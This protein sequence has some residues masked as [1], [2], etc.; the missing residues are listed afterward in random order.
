MI[1]HIESFPPKL[2]PLTDPLASRADPDTCPVSNAWLYAQAAH[3]SDASKIP[4]RFNMFVSPR[5]DIDSVFVVLCWANLTGFCGKT[6]VAEPT[7]AK[8]RDYIQAAL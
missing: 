3:K 6:P 2:Q 5:P 8:A 4:K 7:R 1:E